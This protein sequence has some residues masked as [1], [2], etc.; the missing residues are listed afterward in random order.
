V[1]LTENS[2]EC[3]K[4]VG[5]FQSHSSYREVMEQPQEEEQRQFL[6]SFG[7]CLIWASSYVSSEPE[8]KTKSLGLKW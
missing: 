6:F 8:A 3:R 2:R 5:D 1:G 7:H 4:E